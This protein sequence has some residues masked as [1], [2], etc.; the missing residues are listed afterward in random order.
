MGTMY[1]STMFMGRPNISRFRNLPKMFITTAT[2]RMANKSSASRPANVTRVRRLRYT[3]VTSRAID[4]SPLGHPG[5]AVCH[6]EFGQAEQPRYHQAQA[7]REKM[8]QPAAR[9]VDERE[10][11]DSQCP[12]CYLGRRV[13]RQDHVA[14][15]ID[16]G[17]QGHPVD[18][19]VI[20]GA[21]RSES[22]K[23]PRQAGNHQTSQ[24]SIH[25]VGE[26]LSLGELQ[27]CRDDEDRRQRRHDYVSDPVRQIQ[28]PVVERHLR[29]IHLRSHPYDTIASTSCQI[30]ETHNSARATAT[31][32]MNGFRVAKFKIAPTRANTAA[33]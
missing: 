27:D 16:H 8:T 30:P 24:S 10:H 5:S 20:P 21:L 29:K 3:G 11:A 31:N 15:P 6:E 19:R 13:H 26:F 18:I 23:G 1:C 17:H 22:L 2:A 12:D 25:A 32:R 33:I 4:S 7:G 9:G 28:D 14:D